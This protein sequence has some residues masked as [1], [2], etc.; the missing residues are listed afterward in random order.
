MKKKVIILVG[1]LILVLILF[2][3]YRILDDGR[4]K[5]LAIIGEWN[6]YVLLENASEYEQELFALLSDEK[7][8]EE[9]AEIIFKLFIANFYSLEL[10]KTSSDVR[11]VQFVYEPFQDDIINIGRE[12]IYERVESSYFGR[13]Q[14][15]LPT[16][17]DVVID[18][19]E[20]STFLIEATEETEEK[21]YKSYVI[22]GEIVYD[23]D[24]GY[25]K[26]LVGEVIINNGRYDMVS[27]Q[28]ELFE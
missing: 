4:E 19:I 20:E 8:D 2:N 5:E 28:T 11:G 23:K 15:N 13:R 10:A 12:S 24:Q 27:L 6:D 18:E 3:T 26:E 14:Q 22:S 16:V 7:S 1:W 17:V 25:R 21:E 9:L